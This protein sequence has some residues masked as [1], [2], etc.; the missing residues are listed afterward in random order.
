M[1][2]LRP[3][4]VWEIIVKGARRGASSSGGVPFV[5]VTLGNFRAGTEFVSWDSHQNNFRAVKALSEVLDTAW[6]ALLED[7]GSAACW[8][9][10]WSCGWVS[11]AAPQ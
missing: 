6:S 2:G 4:A 1:S 3:R 5:D 9:A 10:L 8:T 11:S 7:P